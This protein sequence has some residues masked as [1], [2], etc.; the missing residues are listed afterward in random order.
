MELLR[1]GDL[2]N[3]DVSAELD[4]Y[5]AD[6]GTGAAVGEVSPIADPLS[7]RPGWHQEMPWLP[8]ARGSGF[9]TSAGPSSQGPAPRILRD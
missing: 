9:A 7:K 5:L 8:L 2:V 3:L 4:G 1:E 6:T